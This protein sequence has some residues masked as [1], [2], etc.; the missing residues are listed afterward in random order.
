[1]G[2]HP[3]RSEPEKNRRSA[4]RAPVNGAGELRP[5][6]H[7]ARS[8]PVP[9]KVL[10]VSA[11]GVAVQYSE[12]L[13]NGAQYVVRQESFSPTQPSLYTVTRSHV[14]RD[15]S[16]LI[17][18]EASDPYPGSATSPRVRPANAPKPALQNKNLAAVSMIAAVM[19]VITVLAF[20]LY[21]VSR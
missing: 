12:A 6:S 2:N 3:S 14:K 16:V 1:M 7:F 4:E 8:Q 15:G 20:V 21:Q 11:R 9:V 5:C 13:P 17:G 10:D 18:L 19:S